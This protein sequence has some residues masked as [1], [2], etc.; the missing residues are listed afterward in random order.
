[1][2][3]RCR[4]RGRREEIWDDRKGEGVE[5]TGKGTGSTND[6]RYQSRGGEELDESTY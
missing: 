4:L 3:G 6:S 1:M 5:H 2:V